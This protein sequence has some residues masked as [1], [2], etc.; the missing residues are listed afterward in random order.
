MP[1]FYLMD[2]KQ[3]FALQIHKAGIVQRVSKRQQRLVERTR[4]KR[5]GAIRH[6]FLQKRQD[7]KIKSGYCNQQD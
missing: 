2:S 3:S 1:F 6:L 7:L 4:L 5:Q